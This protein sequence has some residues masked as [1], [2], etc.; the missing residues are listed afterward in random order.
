[1]FVGYARYHAIIRRFLLQSVPERIGE[2]PDHGLA[3]I[4]NQQHEL[5]LHT[6][7]SHCDLGTSLGL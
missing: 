2:A 6:L 3:V 5:T 1:M 4:L 7:T